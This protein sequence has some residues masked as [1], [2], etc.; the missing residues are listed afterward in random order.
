MQK[1]QKNSIIEEEKN[2][3][4]TKK[5]EGREEELQA[6]DLLITSHFDFCETVNKSLSGKGKL[7]PTFVL[8]GNTSNSGTTLQKLVRFSCESQMATFSA[9]LAKD[10]KTRRALNARTLSSF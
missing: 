4:E 9:H 10:E 5:K 6:T 1:K 7:F 2:Q 8:F 3:T